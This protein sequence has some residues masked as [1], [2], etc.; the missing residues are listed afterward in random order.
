M[1]HE[2][3]CGRE[4]F[5]LRAPKERLSLVLSRE[6]RKSPRAHAEESR[7][8]AKYAFEFENCWTPNQNTFSFVRDSPYRIISDLVRLEK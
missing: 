5:Y 8:H 4:R 1:S 3:I 7:F 6:H 2:N